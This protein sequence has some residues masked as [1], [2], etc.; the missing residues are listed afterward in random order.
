MTLEIH[1]IKKIRM[2]L[3][4]NTRNDYNTTGAYE[5]AKYASDPVESLALLIRVGIR[6]RS[7]WVRCRVRRGRV[8]HRRVRSRGS[9]SRDHA[10]I[11]RRRIHAHGRLLHRLHRLHGLLHVAA[12][13]ALLDKDD[14][15]G[16][17]DNR[18]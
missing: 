6:V 12:R 14:S 5:R 3:Y 10:D 17:F 13:A 8:R 7:R 2:K 4:F 9:R 15:G 16:I 11:E 18:N 1:F